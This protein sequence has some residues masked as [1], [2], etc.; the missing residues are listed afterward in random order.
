MNSLQPGIYLPFLMNEPKP[1]CPTKK[2]IF[3]PNILDHESA[4]FH[5][6]SIQVRFPKAPLRKAYGALFDLIPIH[7][8]LLTSL[9]K[10][11]EINNSPFAKGG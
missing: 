2:K 7:K 9:Y 3:P 4:T 8:S 11:E 10:R 6:H 1:Q 5:L